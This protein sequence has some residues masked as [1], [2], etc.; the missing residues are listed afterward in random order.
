MGARGAMI[1]LWVNKRDWL[2]P[3]PILTVGLQNAYSL[4]ANG[5]KTHLCCGMGAASDTARELGGFY[6]LPP[7]ENLTVHRLEA[8]QW[9]IPGKGPGFY[10]QACALAKRLTAG[11]RVA[12]LTR[13]PGF[14]PYLWW[15]CRDRR[16]RGFYEAHNFLADLSWREESPGWAERRDGWMERLW[17]PR[18]S[19]LVAITSKQ[20]ELYA[21]V[22]PRLA[23]CA[24]PL[25]TWPREVSATEM[26]RRRGLRTLVYVGHLHRFKG[27]GVL[28]KIARK[29]SSQWG[30]K[31]LF[32]GGAPQ[33]LD[34]FRGEAADLVSGGKVEFRPFLSP[35]DLGGVLA[36]EASIGAVLLRDTFYNRHLTSP[37][38]ALDYLSHGLP[39]VATDLPST[40]EVLGDA[41]LYP[42][43]KKELKMTLVRLLEEPGAYAGAVGAV[44]ARARELSWEGR[45]RRLA[46]FI[47]ERFEVGGGTV[48]I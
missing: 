9:L 26:E 46:A 29:M 32:V 38:K 6:G 20:R 24:L 13:D 41:G 37:A 17:L 28:L 42:A 10:S 14:L 1:C 25:G 16:I 43:T 39:V 3:G 45:A 2:H 19:G 7:S 30:L 5:I 33:Q 8:R 35:R 15:L 22:F 4:A 21:R 23:S 31:V 18:L 44:I 48:A 27:V 40:R 34:R 36:S 11:D 47:E 12:V